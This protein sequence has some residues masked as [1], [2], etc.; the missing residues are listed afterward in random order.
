MGPGV[1]FGVGQAP[2]P[3]PPPLPPLRLAIGPVVAPARGPADDDRVSVLARG[4][5]HEG[6]PLEPARP[7]VVRVP[8]DDRRRPQDRVEQAVAGQ[9]GAG[10]CEVGDAEVFAQDEGDAADDQRT[11]A[12]E[13]DEWVGEEGGMVS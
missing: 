1:G 5:P 2:V 8:K 9:D 7:H 3:P 4:R 13:V 10:E 6:E 12:D 11:D